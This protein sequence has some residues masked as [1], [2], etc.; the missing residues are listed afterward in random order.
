MNKLRLNRLAKIMENWQQPFDFGM[1]H[2]LR[3]LI[4]E[5]DNVCGTACCIAG[6]AVML[7]DP[8]AAREF[9]EDARDTAI[10]HESNYGE[11]PFFT[12]LFE[13]ATDLLELTDDQASELFTPSNVE[14]DSWRD[15]T[16]AWAARCIRKL[17]ATGE[18]DWL[19]TR[20]A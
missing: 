9:I 5:D 14:S 1:D 16:P 12:G 4:D 3:V 18:V 13:I 7:M 20:E 10:G 17:V 6:T 11:A 2:G 19:G 8:T 15:I